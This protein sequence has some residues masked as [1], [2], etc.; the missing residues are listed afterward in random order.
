MQLPSV[1][2]H[3]TGAPGRLNGAARLTAFP[4]PRQVKTVSQVATIFIAACAGIYWAGGTFY[5]SLPFR[6]ERNYPS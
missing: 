6:V 3:H 5:G 1:C 2:C 4:P